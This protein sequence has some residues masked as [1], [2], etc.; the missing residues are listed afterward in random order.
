M[1]M[2][3]EFKVLKCKERVLNKEI[4]KF[5]IENPNYELYTISAA[6]VGTGVRM[7]VIW[8]LKPVDK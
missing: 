1:I 5:R 8:R 7:F 4:S 6:D 3:E 2:N